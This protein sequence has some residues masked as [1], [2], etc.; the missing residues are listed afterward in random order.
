MSY[1]LDVNILLYA[2]DEASPYHQ[3]A[4]RFLA[5]CVQR[6]EP[7][8]LTWGTLMGYL[9]M[10]THPAIFAAPL[11]P[12]QAEQNVA[13]LVALPQ[14]RV[15]AEKEGFLEIYREITGTVVVRGNL[16]PDAHLAA[17]LRQHRIGRV[18]SHDRDF[19][20]FDFL[21]VEDPFGPA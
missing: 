3:P 21:E 20:K 12:R 2:S 19:R 14:A 13:N 1:G 18:V 7:M 11:S 5:D 4:R 15:L 8:C 6:L 16:V 10:A 9:R 17:L